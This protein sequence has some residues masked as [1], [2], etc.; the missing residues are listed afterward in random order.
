MTLWSMYEVYKTGQRINW[1]GL[2]GSLIQFG[3]VTS[4]D[5]DLS[6]RSIL[7]I[8]VLLTALWDADSWFG[9]GKSLERNSA[10]AFALKSSKHNILIPPHILYTVVYTSREHGIS[11]FL[12]VLSNK[13]S[14]QTVGTVCNQMGINPCY[15][16]RDTRT[17][18]HYSCQ[19]ADN[20][21]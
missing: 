8:V 10:I 17:S 11:L 5:L 13:I 12:P 7:E 3:T 9:T 16:T 4:T 19:K 2:K 21:S 15:K 14:T 6:R 1:S 18:L 20:Q